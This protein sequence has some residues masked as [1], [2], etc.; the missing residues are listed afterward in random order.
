MILE[1]L[2]IL[3][4]CV[5]GIFGQIPSPSAPYSNFTYISGK[6]SVLLAI[7]RVGIVHSLIGGAWTALPA[8]VPFTDPIDPG[9]T[10]TKAVTVGASPD[11]W[12]HMCTVTGEA[13]RFNPT[14]NAWEYFNSARC[15]Q[16]NA[17]NKNTALDI[18]APTPTADYGDVQKL[19]GALLIPTWSELGGTGQRTNQAFRWSKWVSVGEDGEIWTI[20]RAGEVFRFNAA[21]NN[22]DGIPILDALR[23]EVRNA[24]YATVVTT[25]CNAW[26]FRSGT[27][28]K[29]AIA[30]CPKQT[31]S[32][33]NND[34]YLD[35]RG[36][37]GS[38]H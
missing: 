15:L 28:T 36:R 3:S 14:S 25:G 20:S 13:Y 11:G 35:G 5:I 2:L 24:S 37:F 6:G 9:V 7:D 31:T 23:L 16:I 27:W 19:N 12:H 18:L 4:V 32:N 29:W 22:F 8:P 33:S 34:Y 21:T 10:S 30:T 1:G 38:R 26:T 17:L